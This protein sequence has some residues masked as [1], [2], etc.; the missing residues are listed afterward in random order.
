MQLF[1]SSAFVRTRLR[2][3]LESSPSVARSIPQGVTQLTR[4]RRFFDF[5]P[6]EWRSPKGGN[7]RNRRSV[8]PRN[9]ETGRSRS[10]LMQRGRFV[11]LFCIPRGHVYHAVPRVSP[12][13]PPVS[14]SSR[15]YVRSRLSLPLRQQP[16]LSAFR[17]LKR[18]PATWLQWYA[19]ALSTVA[20]GQLAPVFVRL[21]SFTVTLARCLRATTVYPG[22][23]VSVRSNESDEKRPARQRRGSQ[24]RRICRFVAVDFFLSLSLS[25]SL[26]GCLVDGR[27]ARTL[28]G[29]VPR[30]PR[31]PR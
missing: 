13:H 23:F 21:P 10:P 9:T 12:S 5:P 19:G 17:K 18:A 4:L 28:A 27:N 11:P 25:L 20:A 15:A 7:K 14:L 1:V 16:S 3:S 26:S 31:A 8:R 6:R 30:N 24:T 22:S 29:A 2:D